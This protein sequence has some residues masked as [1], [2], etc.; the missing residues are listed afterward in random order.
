LIE[1]DDLKAQLDYERSKNA[2]IEQAMKS[3]VQ[4]LKD[5]DHFIHLLLSLTE[6]YK[7]EKN[8]H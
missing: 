4:K 5:F 1:N 3:I 7:E 2:K 8:K 6:K